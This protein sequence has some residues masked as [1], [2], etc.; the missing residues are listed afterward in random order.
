MKIGS[1]LQFTVPDKCP[2]DCR[3]K[4]DFRNYG[5]NAVCMHCPVLCC[6]DN[7][8]DMSPIVAANNFRDDWAAEWELFFKN[9]TE[10]EL[11]ITLKD[12]EDKHV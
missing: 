9:G 6:W 1:K 10:P 3:Y 5:Q 2:A 7:H 11:R 8:D 12:E 4:D